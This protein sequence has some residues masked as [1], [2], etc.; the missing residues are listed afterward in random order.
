MKLTQ[1]EHK[2][3]YELRTLIVKHGYWSDEVNQFNSSI[4]YETMTKIN[5]IIKNE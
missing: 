3:L 5:N 4:S 1:K 2:A